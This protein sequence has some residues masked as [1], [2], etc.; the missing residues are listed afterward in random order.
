MTITPERAET[1]LFSDPYFVSFQ[2]LSV[3]AD[4]D[5]T[6]ID[7]VGEG[8]RVGVQNGTTGHIFA[9][10]NLADKGVII[11]PYQGGQEC[12]LAMASGEVDGVIIDIPVAV[13]QAAEGGFDLKTIPLPDAEQE[14]FGFS[15]GKSRTELAEAI[16]EALKAIIADGTYAEIYARWID[17]DNPPVM[18]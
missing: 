16:N 2:A 15:M 3:P 1:I 4:S 11:R 10:E 7:Q 13:N 5:I 12:F 18:P 14:N 9:T 17:A 8:F 6:S